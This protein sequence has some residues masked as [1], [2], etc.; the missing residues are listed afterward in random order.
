MIL[1]SYSGKNILNL[2]GVRRKISERKDTAFGGKDFK[3]LKRICGE[4]L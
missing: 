1:K 3:G 4:Q 2:H